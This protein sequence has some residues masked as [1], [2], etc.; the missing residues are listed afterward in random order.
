MFHCYSN[1]LC[2]CGW[3][4]VAGK[5]SKRERSDGEKERLWLAALS[6]QGSSNHACCQPRTPGAS[7]RQ[8]HRGA[9]MNNSCTWGGV[10]AVWAHADRGSL[11]CTRSLG[12]NIFH[13]TVCRPGDWSCGCEI[14]LKGHI[15][16]K[17]KKHRGRS[18]SIRFVLN[19]HGL[20]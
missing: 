7:N 8:G 14:P 20:I 9:K 16:K 19:L 11:H 18:S 10:R 6:W 4:W 1:S 3:K 13:K 15:F 17:K 12:I 5:K 2:A